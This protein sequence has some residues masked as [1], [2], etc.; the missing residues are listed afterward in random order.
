MEKNKLASLASKQ[1]RRLKS[2]INL[3]LDEN[4]KTFTAW[5]INSNKIKN[6]G[7]L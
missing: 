1:L 7:L 2:P 6:K 3:H 5:R 4:P